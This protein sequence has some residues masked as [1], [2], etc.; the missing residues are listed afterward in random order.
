MLILVAALAGGAAKAAPPVL[1]VSLHAAP[2]DRPLLRRAIATDQLAALRAWRAR[3]LVTGYRLLFGRYSDGDQW[4]ALELLRFRDEASL[5]RWRAAAGE[6]FVAS[7][8]A[9]A[10]SIETTPA[11]LARSEGARSRNPAVLVI[12]YETLVPPTDYAA[13]LDGYTIPQFRGWMKAGVLDGFDI[14]LSRYPAGRPWHALITLRYHDDAALGRRDEI[15]RSTRAALSGD[16]AWKAYADAKKNVRTE[17]KLAVADE[18]AA[19]G[20]V[21]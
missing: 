1:V 16:Q 6:P 12:P 7:V 17:H 4:D 19:D 14:A 21:E 2:A 18:I 15:V 13:Y 8:A 10:R 11:D 9:L 3:G 20:D 5:A